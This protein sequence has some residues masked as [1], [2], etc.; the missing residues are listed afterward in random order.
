MYRDFPCYLFSYCLICL[1]YLETGFKL[2]VSFVCSFSFLYFCALFYIYIKKNFFWKT[3]SYFHNNLHTV[4]HKLTRK[5]I[6]KLW[7]L[8]NI[9]RNKILQMLFKIVLAVA[10]PF[11]NCSDKV[12]LFFFVCSLTL[13]LYQKISFKPWSLWV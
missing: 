5:L 6:D 11:G 3:T 12:Q 10:R 4:S 9:Q 2:L 8:S 1:F 13:L 7:G